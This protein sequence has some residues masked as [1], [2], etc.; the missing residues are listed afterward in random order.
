M[1]LPNTQTMLE[2]IDFLM[3]L[4]TREERNT[5]LEDEEKRKSLFPEKDVEF[6]EQRRTNEYRHIKHVRSAFSKLFPDIEC[7]HDYTKDEFYMMMTIAAFDFKLKDQLPQELWQ[8]E[9]DRHLK[10][11][12]HHPEYERLNR[13]E[14]LR[15]KDMDVAEMAVDRLSRNLQ[16]SGGEY[17]DESIKKFAPKFEYD[18]EERLELYFKFINEFKQTVKTVWD[19]MKQD[20]LQ[21]HL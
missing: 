6:Y 16:F 1:E 7:H 11:E 13:D 15:I 3:T 14:G 17:D 20:S 19:E 2:V 9:L 12:P 5:I 4:E 18:S 8:N 10:A 21:E